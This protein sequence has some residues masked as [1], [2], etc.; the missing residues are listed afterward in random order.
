VRHGIARQAHAAQHQKNPDG[1]A[2]DREDQRTGK[3]ALHKDIL[4]ERIDEDIS[5]GYS[6]SRGSGRGC[7]A[8]P[9][10]PE[11]AE[12]EPARTKAH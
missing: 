3:R 2:A 8:A 4:D 7:A 1:T 12:G 10:D 6:N 5:H 9:P 11:G